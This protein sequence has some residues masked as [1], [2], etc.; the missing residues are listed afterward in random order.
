MLQKGFIQCLSDWVSETMFSKP[1]D[2][3]EAMQ[4]FGLHELL[5]KVSDAT[6][7]MSLFSEWLV[8][9]FNSPV[10]NNMSGLAYFVK[11]NP[12]K[13]ES[14]LLNSYRC[15]LS[16]QVGF[17]EIK[18][19]FPG[20]RVVLEN[21][22]GEQFD[23]FDI[24]TSLSGIKN[25]TMWSRIA[26]VDGTYQM[27]GSSGFM[28]PMIIGSHTKKYKITKENNNAKVAAHFLI[29]GFGPESQNNKVKQ[30]PQNLTM[31][32][33]LKQAGEQFD[34]ALSV[35]GMSKMLSSSTLKKW[36]NKEK[37]YGLDFPMKALFYLMSEDI[38]DA[39]RNSILD[40]AQAYLS[41]YRESLLDAKAAVFGGKINE[42]S[43][44]EY[45]LNMYSYDDYRPEY[46]RAF[47]SI[48]TGDYQRAYTGYENF[49]KRILDEQTP[50]VLVFRLYANAALACFMNS[51]KN[52]E[53]LGIALINAS[54]RL[55]P[56][57]DF[58][59]RQYEQFVTPF[60]DNANVVDRDD[61]KLAGYLRAKIVQAGERQYRKTPFRYY[62]DF[63]VKAG[64]S[65]ERATKTHVTVFS[66]DPNKEGP[67]K[68]GRNEPCYCGSNKKFKKCCG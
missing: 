42:V 67:I 38:S 65:L 39:Q 4:T 68:I 43:Q 41:L 28:L 33:T 11:C 51:D 32:M 36:V 46:E 12:S 26:S 18:E 29:S 6:Q 59:K 49:V 1:A 64:V 22:S 50:F 55:N 3:E 57:Y 21:M 13:L 15:L 7:L 14:K 17:F 56:Q 52:M 60:Y 16:F 45:E 19:V 10:F 37:Q 34:E 2:L 5:T 54:L 35:A 47:A 66:T 44:P 61:I 9:D 25:S 30:K 40:T 62:E 63:L 27:I 20:E 48:Q 31:G 23:V 58:G 24:N 8:Y 53:G